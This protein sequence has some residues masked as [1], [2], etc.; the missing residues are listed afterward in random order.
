MEAE[1]HNLVNAIATFSGVLGTLLC[2][3]AGIT[4]FLGAYQLGGYGAM[5]IFTVGTGLMV[6]A[7]L[8]KLEVL[9]GRRNRP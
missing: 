9:L 6:F 8:V 3:I 4:R 5:A 7:C 2:I 1:M